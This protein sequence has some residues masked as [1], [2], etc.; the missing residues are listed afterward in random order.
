MTIPNVTT[1]LDDDSFFVDLNGE[2]TSECVSVFFDLNGYLLRSL[3]TTSERQE[4]VMIIENPQQWVY[5]LMSEEPTGIITSSDIEYTL[6]EL[7][8]QPFLAVDQT[9]PSQL[10]TNNDIKRAIYQYNGYINNEEAS[11]YALGVNDENYSNASSLNRSSNFSTDPSDTSESFM[12]PTFDGRTVSVDFSLI[13]NLLTL[14]SPYFS[15]DTFS[16]TFSSYPDF[17]SNFSLGTVAGSASPYVGGSQ[18]NRT[19]GGST[20]SSGPQSST[21]PSFFNPIGLTYGNIRANSGAKRWRFG[22]V[23]PWAKYWF[24]IY[25]Y[26][27][28]GGRVVIFSNYEEKTN[29][30]RFLQD[31]ELIDK[32]TQKKY[33][34]DLII[35]LNKLENELARVVSNLRKDCICV[36]YLDRT[37]TETIPGLTASEGP[38]PPKPFIENLGGLFKLRYIP[39]SELFVRGGTSGITSGFDQSFGSSSEFISWLNN[40][41]LYKS[42]Y[43]SKVARWDPDTGEV[44]KSSYGLEEGDIHIARFYDSYHTMPVKISTDALDT[45]VFNDDDYVSMG[46]GLHGSHSNH[47]A[48]EDPLFISFIRDVLGIDFD[49]ET[50]FPYEIRGMTLQNSTVVAYNGENYAPMTIFPV[51]W[52]LTQEFAWE[53][54]ARQLFYPAG[55]LKYFGVSGET[56]ESEFYQKINGITECAYKYT[57]L[58]NT[59]LAT[60]SEGDE[61]FY[62]VPAG[63]SYVIRT[64]N[65]VD[66]SRN[67]PLENW[68]S[69]API[70]NGAVTH[71][72]RKRP[73][74]DPEHSTLG[75]S[76]YYPPFIDV[77]KTFNKAR[78]QWVQ[79]GNHYKT[80]SLDDLVFL[81]SD[82]NNMSSSLFTYKANNWYAQPLTSV[83]NI[84][85]PS[86]RHFP[87]IFGFGPSREIVGPEIV[88]PI[89]QNPILS[90]LAISAD[91]YTSLWGMF[92]NNIDSGYGW[93]D[94]TP[95]DY[96]VGNTADKI[97]VMKQTAIADFLDYHSRV[98]GIINSAN[99]YTPTLPKGTSH[100][101]PGWWL[102]HPDRIKYWGCT[103]AELP[104]FFREYFSMGSTGNVVFA[105]GFPPAPLGPPDGWND[106]DCIEFGPNGTTTDV[107]ASGSTYCAFIG[108]RNR[109]PRLLI[110]NTD[111]NGS[112]IGATAQEYPSPV[113]YGPYKMVDNQGSSSLLSGI[114]SNTHPG[115]VRGGT[116]ANLYL[117]FLTMP[118]WRVFDDIQVNGVPFG[119][120]SNTFWPA[121]G[122]NNP[123]ALTLRL[124]SKYDPNP[125]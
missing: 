112:I 70:T 37:F 25:N 54:S 50:S 39:D 24:S 83:L 64:P 108:F 115:L 103:C 33:S 32:L 101:E 22:P 117:P 120:S 42:T 52:T 26:L 19:I 74:G 109:H 31:Y 104:S 106:I 5:R 86:H 51:I 55:E 53:Y 76:P 7:F 88:T 21:L 13:D 93:P 60:P 63:Y 8:N 65:A 12:I 41:Y 124:K 102:N 15:Y 114:T 110:H 91:V 40:N 49:A 77:R 107:L 66:I 122:Y 72:S 82:T 10:Y 20:G 123:Q 90:G 113:N 79:N 18:T 81:P 116:F 94:G 89:N 9:V 43:A 36:T 44:T 95:T 118:G 34:F 80:A 45:V 84:A 58:F 71:S 62:N 61:I 56:M 85:L 100:G 6:E 1:T 105:S 3:G 121:Y 46:P 68:E 69:P 92:S 59:L 28:Y 30:N 99:I 78:E 4:G 14:N 97:E 47:P 73:I 17:F 75:S 2:D 27:Q 67:I 48:F 111:L 119:R 125:L 96:Y 38:E 29:A 98:T 57:N 11:S 16:N 23:F 87:D 35:S